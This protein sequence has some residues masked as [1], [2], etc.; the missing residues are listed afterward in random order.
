MNQYQL[1]GTEL[2]DSNQFELT[3]KI[4]YYYSIVSTTTITNK[5]AYIYIYNIM[6]LYPQG[7]MDGW[8][9]HPYAWMDGWIVQPH[10]FNIN[11]YELI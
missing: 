11:S 3:I 5:Y 2:I 9:V 7:Q 10:G 1:K 8:V 6:N 4:N